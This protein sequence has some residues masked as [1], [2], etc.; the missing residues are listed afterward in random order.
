[1]LVVKV[2]DATLRRPDTKEEDVRTSVLWNQLT[3]SQTLIRKRG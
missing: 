2:D 3:N 1:M